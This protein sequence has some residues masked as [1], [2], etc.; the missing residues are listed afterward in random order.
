MYNFRL[1]ECLCIPVRWKVGFLIEPL[2]A[3]KSRN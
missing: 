1:T 3:R 2:S